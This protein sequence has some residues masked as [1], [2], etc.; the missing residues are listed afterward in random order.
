MATQ[1]PQEIAVNSLKLLFISTSFASFFELLY[2][3]NFLNYFLQVKKVYRRL[4][5]DRRITAP[6][7]WLF[8]LHLSALDSCPSP[9]GM[10][11]PGKVVSLLGR[12][13]LLHLDVNL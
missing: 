9:H 5:L 3:G 2:N 6:R 11:E 8:K 12:P 1:I 7:C 13:V 10:T 4:H